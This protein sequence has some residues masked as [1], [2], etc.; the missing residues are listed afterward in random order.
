M[1][2][3]IHHDN[4]H[5]STAMGMTTTIPPKS[6]STQIR[7]SIPPT[8]TAQRRTGQ[9]M[10]PARR[11]SEQRGQKIN[12][13]HDSTLQGNYS[14]RIRRRTA[15]PEATF[16]VFLFY[17]SCFYHFTANIT[18]AL[19]LEAIKRKAGTIEKVEKNKAT[20]A[21]THLNRNHHHHHS[22]DLGPALSL[23][24]L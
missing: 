4:I 2:P 19:P 15:T 20:T 12:I 5:T 21:R 11:T 10:S 3:V 14:H 8:F 24:S 6:L 22:R 7:V 13:P 17:F 23:E 18:R 16:F 1:T 9:D